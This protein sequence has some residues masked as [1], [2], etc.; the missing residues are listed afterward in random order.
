MNLLILSSRFFHSGRSSSTHLMP[1]VTLPLW[2]LSPL[3]IYSL[4]SAFCP[5]SRWFYCFRCRSIV[6][7]CSK[8]FLI[9]I[10][11]WVVIAR[12][13]QSTCFMLSKECVY[14]HTLDARS[15]CT[16]VWANYTDCIATQ[17]QS[18]WIKRKYPSRSEQVTDFGAREVNRDK[19]EGHREERKTMGSH[20]TEEARKQ[21]SQQ[22]L[23]D[24]HI[25][26]FLHIN[27]RPKVLPGYME[28]SIIPK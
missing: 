18:A 5:H 12:H 14:T 16:K 10:G 17:A 2:I 4:S 6:D 24:K 25:S 22:F 1:F 28:K 15:I 11:L 26:C 19:D 7:W 21:I 23:V 8:W 9:H 27:G 13:L 3:Y 20:R